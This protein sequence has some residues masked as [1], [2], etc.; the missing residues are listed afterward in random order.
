MRK[1][2]VK[3]N[4]TFD[5]IL[6]MYKK[7]VDLGHVN[8][9][10]NHYDI[11]NYNSYVMSAD[12]HN[13]EQIVTLNVSCYNYDDYSQPMLPNIVDVVDDNG[14]NDNVCHSNMIDKLNEEN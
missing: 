9:V 6:S 14:Y 5:A 7:L 11:N 12:V 10:Q 2:V 13:G 4:L 8:C 3:L 1:E